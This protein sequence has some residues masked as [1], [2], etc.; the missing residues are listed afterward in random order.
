LKPTAKDPLKI[1][2]SSLS[3]FSVSFQRGYFSELQLNDSAIS[4]T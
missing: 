4:L 3:L 1:K 2:L